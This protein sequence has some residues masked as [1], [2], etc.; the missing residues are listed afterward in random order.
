MRRVMTASAAALAWTQFALGGLIVQYTFD[1]GGSNPNGIDG[2]SARAT[3]DLSGFGDALMVTLENTSTGVPD[4]AEVADVMLSSLAFNLGQGFTIVS[5]DSALIGP[6][7]V[8]LGLW[9]GLLEGDDVGEQWLWKNSGGADALAS[10]SQVIST[11][12]SNGGT[13]TTSFT[14]KSDP[15][16]GDPFGGMAADPPLLAIPDEKPAVSD[17]IIFALTLSD[18]I[19]TKS[20]LWD[21]AHGSVVEFGSGYQYLSVV[22]I[23]GP[24]VWSLMMALAMPRGSRR[25]S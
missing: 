10:F 7:S 17:S 22:P 1:A 14:G 15:D 5:G 8:G 23:P 25:R 21:L 20:Q 24:A 16:V 18:A 12:N 3:F 13:G 9:D 6:G 4:Q 2:M 19:T 11:N